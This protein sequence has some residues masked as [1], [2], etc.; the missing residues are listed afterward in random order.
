MKPYR[1][2]HVLSKHKLLFLEHNKKIM[3]TLS[4]TLDGCSLATERLCSINIQHSDNDLNNTLFTSVSSVTKWPLIWVTRTHTHTQDYL[5]NSSSAAFTC[6]CMAMK[7]KRP[8]C[9]LCD[10]PKSNP[11]SSIYSEEPLGICADVCSAVQPETPGD[12]R[13]ALTLMVEREKLNTAT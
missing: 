6:W 10:R 3:D 4:V 12:L 1:K 2:S 9:T 8:A 7:N 13:S 5:I 11:A